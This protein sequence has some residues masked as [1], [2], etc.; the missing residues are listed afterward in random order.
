LEAV[1][2][3]KDLQVLLIIMVDK[4]DQVLLEVI[5][6]LEVLQLMAEDLVV[7]DQKH[8]H[9]LLTLEVPA[10]M[11]VVDQ[12]LLTLLQELGEL[13]INLMHQDFLVLL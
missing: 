2:Q 7:E 3:E 13:L 5:L 1:E 9:P 11:A 12:E 4:V 8:L 6:S 10:V